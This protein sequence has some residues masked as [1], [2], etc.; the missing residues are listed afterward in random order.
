MCKCENDGGGV[1]DYSSFCFTSFYFGFWAWLSFLLSF[2]MLEMRAASFSC[3]SFVS[4][5]FFFFCIAMPS[6]DILREVIKC[7][8]CLYFGGW[9]DMLLT[10]GVEV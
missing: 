8:E 2:S 10:S 1:C 3:S 9:H 5:I 4:L 7:E 6:F